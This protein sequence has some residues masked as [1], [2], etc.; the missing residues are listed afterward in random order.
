[1]ISRLSTVIFS[2][3]L[4]TLNMPASAEM[5]MNRVTRIVTPIWM[6][7]VT[8]PV[9]DLCSSITTESSCST[10]HYSIDPFENPS[11][12]SQ[13][14]SKALTEDV[15]GKGH[16]KTIAKTEIQKSLL[17]LLKQNKVKRTIFVQQTLKRISAELKHLNQEYELSALE[18][19][20]HS[21]YDHEFNLILVIRNKKYNVGEVLVLDVGPKT[22]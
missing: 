4:L 21:S 1:M 13:A 9:Q 2:I 19:F 3:L 8:A 11:S 16:Y 10:R 15:I 5:P 18:G 12:A 17:G 14:V 20:E 7:G 6:R 22:F